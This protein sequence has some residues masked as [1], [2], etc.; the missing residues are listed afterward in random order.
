MTKKKELEFEIGD[1]FVYPYPQEVADFCNNN[2]AYLVEIEPTKDGERQFQIKEVP[3]YIPT[4]EEITKLR[5]QYRQK[6]IDDETAR[7][8]RKIAN[9]SWTE[10][11]ETAYLALDAEVTA[12][13]EEHYP[14]AGEDK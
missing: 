8:S 14:Y 13:I 12:Y 1:I 7:R 4:K 3:T 5:R 11:D 9:K 2:N 6:H 10:E